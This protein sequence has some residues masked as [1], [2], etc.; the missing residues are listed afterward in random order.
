LFHCSDASFDIDKRC[1]GF[2]L[3]MWIFVIVENGEHGKIVSLVLI[4]M[5]LFY[6]DL[7]INLVYA[8]ITFF[9]F[10]PYKLF[11]LDSV[12]SKFIN[13]DFKHCRNWTKK[14]NLYG[15]K[16]NNTII[17]R[18]K[19]I[20]RPFIDFVSELNRLNQLNY[21]RR[22]FQFDSWFDF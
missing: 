15:L 3:V 6:L 9:S 20:F 7:N 2:W 17:A 16:Q 22:S 5:L 19:I 1:L 8:I 10:S 14:K 21:G 11:C 12:Y 4:T 13:Y 18:I